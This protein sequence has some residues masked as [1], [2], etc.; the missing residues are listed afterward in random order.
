MAMRRVLFLL[1]AVLA[2]ASAAPAATIL[3]TGQPTVTLGPGDALEFQFG[4]WNF[5]RYAGQTYPARISFLL[6]TAP[7]DS[8][9]PVFAASLESADGGAEL[10]LPDPLSLRPGYM[11][12]T[13]YAGPVSVVSG[14]AALTPEQ[15]AALFGPAAGNPALVVLRNT[16]G[17]VTLGLPNYTIAQMLTVSL[18]GSS[19]S[20]GAPAGNVYLATVDETSATMNSPDRSSPDGADAPEP[21]T[22]TMALP[23]LAGACAWRLARSATSFA[24]ARSRPHQN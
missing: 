1:P 14:S 6:S 17:T 13:W 11:K 2:G 18:G 4:A 22:L 21:A 8:P 15:A 3:V 23:I 16:G 19:M 9:P 5:A 20:V 12:A 24:T 10:D 7:A